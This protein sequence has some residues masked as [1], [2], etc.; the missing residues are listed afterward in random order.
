MK[1]KILSASF[2]LLFAIA[3]I[4][5]ARAEETHAFQEISDHYEAIRVAL[6]NDVM[7]DV[8]EHANAIE[9]IGDKLLEAF[10]AA[11]AGVA[12][13][14]GSACRE[15]LPELSSAAARLAEVEDI[16]GAR[17]ALFE[18]SKPLGRYRKLAGIEGSMVVY[19][20][21]V[22]K[23]WIQPE[24]EVGNPYM[25]QGMPTCGQVIAD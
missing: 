15:L 8:A 3:S 11:S 10:D 1:I 14:H 13:E 2:V 24:G 21:M 22:K 18:L 4:S 7:T 9:S 12:A 16:D 19:C 5:G 17:E 23:A 25:G 6:L 20:P